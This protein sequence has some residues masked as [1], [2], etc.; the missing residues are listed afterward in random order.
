MHAVTSFGRFWRSCCIV[1]LTTLGLVCVQAPVQASPWAEVGDRQLRSDI[2]VLAAYGL[3]DGV[4]TTWPI[5]WVQVSR[6]LDADDSELPPHVRRSLKRVRVRFADETKQYRQKLS[7]SA[8]VT[9]E[10][11]LVRDFGETARRQVDLEAGVEYMW[12]STAFRLNLGFEGDVD[13]S[14]QS[15][16]LDG[17]YIAQEAAN[18]L[19]YGGYVDQWWGGG[20]IGSLILSN[21][22]RAFPKIGVMR[23]DPKAFETPWLSWLG[24]WQ[25]NAFLGL[26]DDSRPTEDPFVF[27]ARVAINPIPGLELGASRTFQICGSGRPCDFGTWRRALIGQD[28]V[29]PAEQA[30]G[31]ADPANQLAGFDARYSNRF[32]DVP[33][34]LYAQFIG[35]DEASGLPS[36]EAGLVGLSLWGGLGDMGAQWRLTA[37]YSDTA[38]SVFKSSKTFDIFYEHDEYPGGYRYHNRSMGSSLDN[39][40]R[41]FTV[42]G[43]LIDTRDWTYRL[44]Y[45]HIDLNRDDSNLPK[46]RG[47][48]VSSNREKINIVEAGMRVPWGL[49]R[50]GLDLRFQ[51]DSP[52]TPG[53]TEAEFAAEFSVDLRF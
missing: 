4:V 51:D 11:A 27:G 40:T 18:L 46:P 15:L 24:P 23:N 44:T 34:S 25:F 21:N 30:A 49:A 3:I 22:A 28:N 42:S 38:P 5:P 45:H 10:P 39:D 50:Y 19:F 17:T 29:T 33:F 13:S 53:R 6:A 16:V 32:F 20:W 31:K 35:E 43:H 47:N 2:E 8:R 14:A 36:K 1:A 7:G 9:N 52:N 37:E 12:S 41:L 48:P 26:L